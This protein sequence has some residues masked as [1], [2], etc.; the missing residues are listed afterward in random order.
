[1]GQEFRMDA[2]KDAFI[3]LCNAW[4]FTGNI[5]GWGDSTLKVEVEVTQQLEAEII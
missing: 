2:E 3:L 5:Q 1:M 4:V